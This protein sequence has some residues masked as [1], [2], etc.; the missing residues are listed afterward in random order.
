MFVQ[1]RKSILAQSQN[2]LLAS[3]PAADFDL[4]R[5][6]LR[7]IEMA[8]ARVLVAADERLSHAYFP[9]DGIISL[10]VSL[11]TGQMVEAAMVGRDSV[12]GASAALDCAVAVND[13]VVQLPGTA[14]IIEVADLRKAVELSAPFRA[15]LIRHEQA[16]FAQALQ[17]AACNA[18]HSA[19]RRL[20]RSLLRACDMSGS[21]TLALTHEFL[22]QMLGI[23]RNSVSIVANTLQQRGLIRYFRGQIEI[24]DR[25]GLAE[26]ACECY[27]TAKRRYEKL[28]HGDRR[29]KLA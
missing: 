7:F 24:I 11:T 16:L 22:G 8:H 28:L 12:Y 4:L 23:Q 25:K 14:T 2:A 26:A 17:S 10:V 27:A 1:S 5:P 19:E 6:R 9:H 29:P 20:A 18:S 15:I 3:L 21:D 13:A